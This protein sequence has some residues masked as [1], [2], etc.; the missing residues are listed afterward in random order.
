VAKAKYYF[1]SKAAEENV[2][3]KVSQMTGMRVWGIVLAVA[4]V[5][6]IAFFALNNEFG[7]IRILPK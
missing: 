2:I 5:L 4:L 7:W 6:T 1:I 3:K